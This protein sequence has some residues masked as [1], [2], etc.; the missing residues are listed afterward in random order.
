MPR[1]LKREK[2]IGSTRRNRGI[3][4]FRFC[5]SSKLLNRSRKEGE[6]SVDDILTRGGQ[7]EKRR[8]EM[9]GKKRE[10][11]E[12]REEREGKRRKEKERREKRRNLC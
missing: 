12:R 11:K 3:S 8:E 7:R 4:L 9:E 10:K 5:F 1:M 6:K 2:Y